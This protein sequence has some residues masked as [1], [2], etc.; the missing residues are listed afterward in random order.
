MAIVLLSALL[1]ALGVW[2]R[3]QQGRRALAFWGTEHASLLRNA[4]SVEV[5]RIAEAGEGDAA[6]DR[7]RDVSAVPD[8]VY[9]RRA[10]L[11]DA[12]FRWDADLSACE[13]RWAYVLTFRDGARTA[14]MWIDDRCDVVRLEETDRRAAMHPGL[15]KS[16][17]R[18]L[19]QQLE[20]PSPTDAREGETT[21]P[22][23]SPREDRPAEGA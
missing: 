15:L 5:A 2:Y 4:P 8:L 3:Y 11:N 23:E 19:A 21:A 16:I 17:R 20:K 14:T 18:F 7:R 9:I 22:A 13:P 12:Y 6:V 1:A 10:L